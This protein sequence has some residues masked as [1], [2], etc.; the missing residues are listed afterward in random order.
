MPW[1][2][3]VFLGLICLSIEPVLQAQF[4]PGIPFPTGRGR[5]S[6]QKSEKE[7]E[8]NLVK[9]E[10]TVQSIGATSLVLTATD[11]RILNLKLTSQ[12]KFREAEKDIEKAAIPVGSTVQV[13]ASQD[14]EGYF[15]ATAITLTKRPANASTNANKPE[16]NE[17]ADA[18]KE[19]TIINDTAPTEA[20]GRPVLRRGKPAPRPKSEEPEEAPV[21]VANSPSLQIES[22]ASKEKAEGTAG[23]QQELITRA[24]EW[25]DSFSEG[26]P[27]YVCQQFTTRY[28]YESKATGWRALDMISAAVVYD[29]GKEEY[30][31][32]AINGKKMNK[33]MMDLPGSRSTGEYGTILKS[34]LASGSRAQFH[35]SGTSRVAG[36]EATIYDYSVAKPYANWRVEV[37][38][39]AIVP[40]YS[41]RIWVDK[42]T[43]HVLRI[44]MQADDI[45]AEFPMDKVETTVEYGS[46]RLSTAS[47]LLPVHSEN[48]A[49]QRGTTVC[50]RNAIDF[51]NYRKY[52]GESTITFDEK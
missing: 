10:G 13:E 4:E 28:Q 21:A 49:C 11:S 3:L 33:P 22:D 19:L 44:E 43:A 38:S 26:L 47:F 2:W 34:L 30:R 31:D 42:S 16:S 12:T 29:D 23:K 37:G 9:A 50:S 27:N 7:R 6:K 35:Y 51:R 15:T 5:G 36:T 46:V 52:A 18:D 41:G 17:N 25:V 48:L 24:R 40:A 45:P 14:K 32:I 1:R 39:Q 20:P 8:A